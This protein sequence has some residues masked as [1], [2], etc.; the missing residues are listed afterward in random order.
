MAHDLDGFESIGLDGAMLEFLIEDHARRRLPRLERLWRYYRNPQGA[1]GESPAPGARAGTRSRQAQEEGLPGR[2][3]GARMGWT[4]DR[5]D[6]REIVIEN[7]IAWRVQAMVDFMFGK[8]VAI[9]STARD[10]A[11]REKIDR[12]LDAVWERSGGIA[13]LQDMALLGHVYGSVDLVVRIDA[14]RGDGR[15]GASGEGGQAGTAPSPASPVPPV[16]AGR[17][18]HDALDR[19]LARAIEAARI[20]IVEPTRGVPLLDP[21]DYRRILGYIITHE[22]ELNRV[23]RSGGFLNSLRRAGSRARSR[24]TEIIDAA[25]RRVYENGVLIE[26]EEIARWTGGRAPIAHVQNTSEPFRYEGLSEVEPLIPLQDE[27]NTRLSDRATRVTMQS[28]KMYLARGLDGFDRVPIGPGRVWSTDNMD[29]SI[30]S[31]GGD[32]DSPSEA[33][34][35]QEVREA[36]DKAS[37]VPPLASGVVRARI[38]NL[39]SANALRITLMGVIAKTSR[40]RVTY[41]RGIVEASAIVLNALDALGLLRTSQSERGIRLQWPDP[42]P[43]DIRE[44]VAVARLQSDLG[45]P[46]GDVLANLD[47]APRDQGVM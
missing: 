28:F 40:K 44:E 3:T 32:A 11:L 35:I 25:Q 23:E 30:Q 13:L 41:G 4:D 12:V 19:L 39:T 27:L 21:S 43:V 42:L 6:T 24:T 31:F 38:G 10:A 18:G 9:R 15:G 33:A 36:L 26:H 29:A 16:S 1:C 5:A 45:V 34:H 20:E 17:I 8:P 14:S 46:R 2:L 37:G 47:L 22:R 7:D